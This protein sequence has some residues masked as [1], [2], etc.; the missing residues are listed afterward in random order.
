MKATW[1]DDV[2]GYWTVDVEPNELKTQSGKAYPYPTS[3]GTIRVDG[4]KVKRTLWTPVG[5]KPRG[6]PDAAKDMLE[7]AVADLAGSRPAGN[8]REAEMLDA[9]R[10]IESEKVGRELKRRKDEEQERGDFI[11]RTSDGR[12][13]ALWEMPRAMRYAE[14]RLKILGRG[15]RAEFFRRPVTGAKPSTGSPWTEPFHAM[16]IDEHGRVVNGAP[17]RRAGGGGARSTANHGGRPGRGGIRGRA[18]CGHAKGGGGSC[19]LT[20]F[21]TEVLKDLRRPPIE[22]VVPYTPL[23]DEARRS[24]REHGFAGW[25]RHEPGVQSL[26]D[27]LVLTPDGEAALAACGV[28]T[29][30]RGQR[31]GG[32]SVAGRASRTS[33]P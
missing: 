27:Y 33:R 6:Y 31:G 7:R 30:P 29:R 1:H 8:R 19:V 21:E 12:E 23:Y 16:E 20:R 24:L 22:R 3:V 18:R 2:G 5:Y 14:E 17:L 4:K 25:H 9:L 32:G 10:A 15:A 11:V 28:P 26:H 13:K